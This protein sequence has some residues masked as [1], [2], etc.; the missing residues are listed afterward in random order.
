MEPGDIIQ[1]GSYARGFYHSLVVTDIEGAP[2]IDTIS[3]ST[4]TDDY[5]NRRSTPIS[6]KKSGFL[7]IGGVYK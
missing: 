4:H 1:L 5:Y 3:I 7:H 2:S 6:S